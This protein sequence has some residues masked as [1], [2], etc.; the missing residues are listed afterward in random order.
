ML[1]SSK[2]KNS[3]KKN[4]F[5]RNFVQC[6]EYGFENVNKQKCLHAMNSENNEI[7]SGDL[8]FTTSHPHSDTVF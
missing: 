7:I 2:Y 8:L 3:I 6:E 1:M 4:I 5:W